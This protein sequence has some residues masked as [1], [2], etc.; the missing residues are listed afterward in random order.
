VPLGA[1]PH[2]KIHAEGL[3]QG[4]VNYFIGN[5]P[6]K[7][8]TDLSTYKAVVYEELYPGIDIRFYGNNRQLEYDIIVKPGADPSMVRM[9]WEG[10]EGLKITKEGDLWIEWGGK[11][12]VQRMPLV[13][14]QIGGQRVKL[15]GQFKL[16]RAISEKDSFKLFICGFEVAAYDKAYPLV[17]DPVF[18]Y[19]TYLGGSDYDEARGIAVDRS[20]NA[21][22]AGGTASADFHTMNPLQPTIGGGDHDAFVAKFNASGSALV[23]STYFGGSGSDYAYGIAVDG[24]GNAYVTGGTSSADFPTMNP[25]QSTI[26][27]SGDAFV[28]KLNAAGSALVYSTYLGGSDSDSAT[29]I[30]V[31]GFGN[32]YVTGGTSSADFPTM[33]PLQPTIGGSGDAFMAKLN[34]AGS[35]LVYSTYLGGSDS[36]SATGIAVD[37]LGNAYLTGWTLSHDFPTMNPLKPTAS[38]GVNGFVAKLNAAGSALV[39]STYLGGSGVVAYGIAL[40]GSGNAYVAG[41]TMIP[42]FPT[43]NPL[44]ATFGGGD[45]DAFV[46][47]LN[48]AGSA[49]VY[50]TYLGG[51]S[52]DVAYGI[53][54]DGSG[55]AYVTGLTMSAD[56][57]TVN[58]LQA[59]I[60]GAGGYDA[61]VAKL[62]AA[63]S[64]L[65]YSTYLGGTCLDSGYG[66]AVDGLGNAYAAGFTQCTG[67]PTANPL[68]A[69]VGGYADAFV[70]KIG[71]V[72]FSGFFSP[73][74]NLPTLNNA[75]AGQTIPVKWRLTDTDEP[76]SDPV[77][78]TNLTSFLINCGSLSGDATS[79]VEEY[80]AGSSG[81]QYLGDGY[82][83]F[84]WKT[85]KTYAGQCRKMVL[86]LGDGSTHEANFKF[87]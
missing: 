54:V 30:A 17:I 62:N 26:G 36:D 34:V 20:G 65:V 55:N 59:T 64:A 76:V 61:F 24:S 25:L 14:Q 15:T 58:P 1:N 56:F 73:V 47:K 78:F 9:A 77:S 60:G 39:Y 51:S 18:V 11:N 67:F 41:F 23:Y 44:Q 74:D 7:W 42:D 86:T 32:A 3:Q 21:Y 37:G 49:L 38:S 6:N 79:T 35:A 27:G 2:P 31:D 45:H 33:N 43:A 19:S 5:D 57:P 84:N 50:S 12:L 16:E 48:A 80:S 75:K 4:K 40:D 87:K 85:P 82:W 71:T 81:L 72:V 70:A 10:I 68:Q 52:T 63:G 53:A 29:G 8:K 69:N 66:I 13:Y 83:Q 46:A 22:V 28:A